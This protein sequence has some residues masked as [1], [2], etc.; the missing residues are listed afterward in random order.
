[1]INKAVRLAK[2]KKYD[3]YVLPGGSC[4]P[5]LLEKGYEA[6]VGVACCDEI[7]LAEKYLKNKDIPFQG[8][9]LLSNGCARTKFDLKM[10]KEIL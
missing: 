6:I 2:R 4:I 10:L 9:P 7:K 8:V 1:L 5:K 3:V